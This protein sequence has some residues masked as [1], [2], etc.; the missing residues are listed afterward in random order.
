MKSIQKYTDKILYVALTILFIMM[1]GVT[2]LNVILRYIFNSPL[3][4]AVELGRYCFCAIVYLGSILVMREDGH[5]GLDII[6][7]AL[8]VRIRIVVKKITR[9]LVLAYLSIFCSMAFRMVL[10]NW[11]N[12][13][14]TMH[15]P[16]SIVYAFMVI[17]SL[18]MFI[19]ELIHLL[20]KEKF[21]EKERKTKNEGGEA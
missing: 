3:T 20:S 21:D 13:S 8:P 6:V 10:T 16:M 15:L 12:R 2:T 1:F 11:K 9:V 18:G 4:F 17:G 19:E 7:D 14:S 5:I